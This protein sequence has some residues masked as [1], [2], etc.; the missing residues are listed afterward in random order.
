MRT[1]ITHK[2][3]KA[4]RDSGKVFIITEMS[5]HQAH[6]WATRA[7]FAVMNSGVELPDN[8]A[9]LGMA[10]LAVMGMGALSGVPYAVAEPLLDE[11]LTCVQIKQDITT[12]ALVPE[13][14]EEAVT[15][16]DLQRQVLTMH[17]EPFISGGKQTSESSPMTP[18]PAA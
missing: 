3:E 4:N 17:I 8:A 10:G 7:I 9:S 1:V 14:I 15:I 18:A 12:R 16:F 6:R 11:L 2:I 5:A 13:D